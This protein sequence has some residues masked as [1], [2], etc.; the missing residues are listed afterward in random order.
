MAAP[1]DVE[2]FPGRLRIT[3][4]GVTLGFNITAL[5]QINHDLPSI[6][7]V[8]RTEGVPTCSTLTL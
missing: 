3:A 1:R 2:R 5:W 4:G 6:L 7:A 8:S